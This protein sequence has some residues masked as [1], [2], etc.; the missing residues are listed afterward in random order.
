MTAPRN[1]GQTSATSASRAGAVAAAGLPGQNQTPAPHRATLM[2][3]RAGALTISGLEHAYLGRS[4]LRGIDLA[5][6]TGE[7]VALVGPSGCGKS[8]LLH[9]AA[10]LLEPKS[11]RITRG[12][13]CHAMIFQEPSL[14]P[15]ATAAD[16]IAFGLRLARLPGRE[17]AA[18]VSEV[19]AQVAL[20]PAD[21]AKYPSELSGGMRQRVA[22]ARAL[23]VRPDFI[24][25]DEPFTALDVALRRRMQDLVIAT[26]AGAGLAG[27]FVTHD[28]HEAARIAHRVAV[29]DLRG[30]GIHGDR[31]VPGVPGQ[32]G[33]TPLHDWVA[34]ALADDPLFAHIHNVDERQIA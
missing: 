11:G 34:R 28:L 26:C 27:L 16:N 2:G 17:H 20:E 24:Y 12:Y 7:I 30:A 1:N 25:F 32:R 9:V 5:V 23:A 14:M 21:L 33:D 18:R 15:W 10:G 31:I 13:A 19:A 22:I 8:T 3:K 29:L 6:S 4:V